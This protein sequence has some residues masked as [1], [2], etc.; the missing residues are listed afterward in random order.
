[1]ISI[2]HQCNECGTQFVIN[3]QLG[4]EDCE[5]RANCPRC[6]T[7]FVFAVKD[8]QGKV[9]V[10]KKKRRPRSFREKVETK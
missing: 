3:P 5:T 7:L 6:R 1:M 2:N 4:P 10:P 8:G 9:L